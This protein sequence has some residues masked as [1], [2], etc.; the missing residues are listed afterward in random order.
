MAIVDSSL[1]MTMPKFLTAWTGLD[2]LTHA[3]ESYVSVLA[4]EFT[5]PISLHACKLIFDNLVASVQ[6]VTKASREAMHHAST[7]AG[8]AFSNAFLGINHS[9]AHKLG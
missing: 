2:A 1:C 4:T 8:M 7:L 9:L 3:I 5:Q 6:T